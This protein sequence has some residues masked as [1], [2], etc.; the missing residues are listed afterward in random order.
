MDFQ[1]VWNIVQHLATAGQR[2]EIQG[3]VS[4][5]WKT[6]ISVGGSLKRLHQAEALRLD[7]SG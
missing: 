4:Q 7:W 1:G 5:A 6:S 3:L 2:Q